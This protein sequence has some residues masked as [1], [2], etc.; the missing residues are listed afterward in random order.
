MKAG[1]NG[2]AMYSVEN[3]AIQYRFG[4]TVDDTF[5]FYDDTANAIRLTISTTGNVGI[6]TTA[7]GQLLSIGLAGTTLGVMSLA[8]STSGV[9][10]VDVL[11][12]AGT[13]TLTLPPND[14]ASGEFLQTDGAGNTVWAA[15]GGGGTVGISGT[16]VA[17]D[18]ARWVNGTTIEGRSYAETM[19]ALSGGATAAFS[20]N[21]Q[22]ITNVGDI[23]VDSISAD[24]GINFN[25]AGITYVEGGGAANELSTVVAAAS[26]GDVIVL[27]PGT[28]TQSVL[29]EIPDAISRLTIKGQGPGVTNIV[30]TADVDGLCSGLGTVNAAGFIGSGLNDA[31][32]GGTFTGTTVASRCGFD[33]E[34]DGTGTP[35]TFKWRK[36]TPP[37]TIGGYTAGV[38]I[39][40]AAQTLSDGVTVTFGAT[41]GHTSG[42]KWL[43]STG[44]RMVHIHLKGFEMQINAAS[45]TKTAIHIFG[46]S[47]NL[48]AAATCII[49]DVT[50]TRLDGGDERNWGNGLIL[51]GV[52]DGR[53]D[54]YNFRGP[55][56]ISYDV[57]GNGLVLQSCTTVTATGGAIIEA[58]NALQFRKTLDPRIEDSANL[59]GS[60]G[61]HYIGGDIYIADTGVYFGERAL[62][63]HVISTNISPCYVGCVVEASDNSLTGFNIVDKCWMDISGANGVI[64]GS[65]SHAV[66]IRKHG[67]KVTNCTINGNNASGSNGIA[68]DNTIHKNSVQGNTIRGINSSSTPLYIAAALYG[69]YC[70]NIFDGNGGSNEILIAAGSNDNTVIAKVGDKAFKDNGTGNLLLTATDGDSL[71]VQY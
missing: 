64:G 19:A 1:T 49:K 24:N 14:G 71:N 34:I 69:S 4:V 13:W 40:G 67:S 37:D 30:Y 16:P 15:G 32:S 42:D 58:E 66:Y 29:I 46:K 54:Y 63:C 39:T 45:T 59:A 47:H 48:H 68:L 11:P 5:I 51:E 12:T 8:G 52:N 31:T 41:T 9:V 56:S 53:I 28:F 21:D 70:N 27:G 33:I 62:D 55:Y 65:N 44:T 61:C 35:D 23:D 26:D 6:G 57:G 43:F 36:H 10:S 38:A 60:E 25:V 22:N 50:C 18:F 17:N 3:D 20:F 7:P 2:E